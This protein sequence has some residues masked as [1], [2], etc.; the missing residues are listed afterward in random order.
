MLE[1][2]T[3]HIETP[4][5]SVHSSFIP[6]IR[7]ASFWQRF[8]ASLI[9]IIILSAIGQL[10]K[11][12]LGEPSSDIAS[13]V[14][15]WL[16]VALLL[17]G[18]W[19]ATLGKRTLGI[20]VV[21]TNGERISFLN[22]TGRHFATIVSAVILFIGYFMMLWSDKKQTLHDMMAGT[23]VVKGNAKPS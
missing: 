13:L 16:Y 18:S 21:G 17:S 15:N 4:G 3:H 14:I 11:T 8:A 6:P 7:Y 22:A 12:V 2:S 9:D 10:L 20:K 5:E 23:F 19:Q 1:P